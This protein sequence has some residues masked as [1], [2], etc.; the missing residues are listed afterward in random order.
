MSCLLLRNVRPMG[1]EAVDLRVEDGV[2]AEI[3]TD[4]GMAGR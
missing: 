3:A 2:I 4:A 1:A